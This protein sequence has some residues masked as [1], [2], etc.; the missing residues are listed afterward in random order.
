MKNETDVFLK[1]LGP[2]YS[3]QPGPP[4]I[5]VEVGAEPQLVHFVLSCQFMFLVQ[6]MYRSIDQHA[7]PSFLAELSWFS[8]VGFRCGNVDYQASEYIG[9]IALCEAIKSVNCDGISVKLPQGQFCRIIEV[10]KTLSVPPSVA[11]PL[12]W[13]GDHFIFV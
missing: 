10:R 13:F 4:E 3:F 8:L 6:K 12:P 1:P 2:S 9:N 11:W 5:H 7:P